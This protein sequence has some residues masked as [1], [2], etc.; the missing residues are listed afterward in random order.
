MYGGKFKYFK[1]HFLLKVKEMGFEMRPDKAFLFKSLGFV[2]KGDGGQSN[3]QII[4]E[5][6][7]HFNHTRFNE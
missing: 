7:S 6:I 1:K 4:L 3:L 2:G 5:F